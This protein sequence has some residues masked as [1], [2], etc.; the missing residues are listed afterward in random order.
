[1]GWRFA[2]RAMAMAFWGLAVAGSVLASE[3]T[4]EGAGDRAGVQALPPALF[5]GSPAAVALH[6]QVLATVDHVQRPFAI[7]DKQRAQLSVYHADGTLAGTSDV[8][9]GQMPGDGSTVDVG[10][11]TQTGRL[12]MQDRTTPAGR[13]DS[14]PGRNLNG[15]GVVWVDYAT[16]FA[17]HRL[18]PAPAA[19]RRAERLAS[20]D[21]QA[22]RISAGCVVVPV[23]FYD[24][25][26]APVLGLG[27]AVVY[28]MPEDSDWRRLLAS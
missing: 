24:A 14:Q 16:A 17:I 5:K 28:V 10:Q 12:R 1:M 7:V 27:R 22:R 8:L 18:R 21:Q 11:R 13:F 23:A 20:A 4:G 15:E 2:V 26:V 6:A 9:L 25:V 3:A 19:Q